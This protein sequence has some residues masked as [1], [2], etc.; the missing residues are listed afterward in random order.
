MVGC[1]YRSGSDR[2]M[3]QRRDCLRS[4][5]QAAIAGGGYVSLVGWNLCP[6]PEPSV[7]L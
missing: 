1:S 2:P 7:P 4:G 6:N 3:P 5:G